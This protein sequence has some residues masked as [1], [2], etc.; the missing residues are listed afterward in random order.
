M[1]IGEFIGNWLKSEERS[2]RWLAKKTGISSGYFNQIVHDK[3]T[4]SI[5]KLK[6]IAAAMDIPFVEFLIKAEVIPPDYS[7][8]KTTDPALATI[9]RIIQDHPDRAKRIAPILKKLLTETDNF[10]EDLPRLCEV[11]LA[12]DPVKRQ[13][14]L[15]AL[16]TE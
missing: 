14:L 6:E 7:S 8:P 9:L 12:M 16:G 10:P 15:T 5:D 3:H 4:P 13:G 11:L 1:T 2:I